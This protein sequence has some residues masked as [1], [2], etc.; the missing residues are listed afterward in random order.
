[1][2]ILMALSQLEVTGAEVYGVTL[3]D[4]LIK[5]GN[6]VYIVSD[7]LT[8]PTDAEYFKIEFN[9]RSLGQRVD[10]V[11]KLLKIIREKDIQVVHAH[12]RASSWSSAIACK[13]AGIP[14]VTTTHGRQPIHF[15]RKVIKGFGDFGITVC[16][17]IYNQLVECLGVKE[18]KLCVLRNPVGLEEYSFSSMPKNNKK[19]ISIIG[20]LSGPKGDVCY[21]LLEK[22]CVDDS[23]TVQVIGGKEIPESF[24]KFE[25][26]VN[27]LGYVNNVPEEIK[28]SDLIIGA[29]RVAIEGILS[30]R[31][32]IAVGEQEYLGLV[33]RESIKKSLASN[34][35]DVNPKAKGVDVSDVLKDIKKSFEMEE[36]ELLELRGI[37]EENFSFD[38]IIDEIEK[39]YARQYVLKKKYD[40]PVI[41]YHRI[42]REN[43]VKGVHGIYVLDKVFDE[44]MK[45]LKESGYQTITFEDIKNGKWRDR[46]NKGN[47]WIMITFDD[48]YTDNYQVAFPILKKYGF[49]ATIYLLGEVKY[50][51]WDVDVKE[52][53]EEKFELM[54]DSQ[55]LEMQDYGIEFGGHTLTHPKLAELEISDARREILESKEILDKKLGRNM[56]VFA[57]PYGSLNED[58]K[59]VVKE[60]GYQFAVATDSGSLSF[61]E[62][63][64]QIRRIAIFPKN[65]MFSFKRKVSGKYN[66][67]KVK[68]EKRKK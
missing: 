13:I 44:Q 30:G 67:V 54:S 65:N 62:D 19:I 25:N 53:P 48:G 36:G 59:S 31:P 29:G 1:M 47:K 57:Y 49:K 6:K 23:Y 11:K 50:N 55:I 61:S 24:K 10:Q 43:D 3:A 2:N 15:S 60:A 5:R 51:K 37:I 45:Y 17:N 21:D 26:K 68:R 16:E 46:F 22:I 52:N 39:I 28:K 14:L 27:F 8:K 58:V 7:T 66:F 38:K 32:V 4:E 40:I 41:M 12:S 63:L 42:I 20:R 56:N 33:T 64:F 9:K 18:D 34:F 35:G